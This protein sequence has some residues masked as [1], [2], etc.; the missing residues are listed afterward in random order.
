MRSFI[1]CGAY[2]EICVSALLS[3]SSSAMI[4]KSR[5]D[6]I[7]SIAIIELMN[8]YN[9]STKIIKSMIMIIKKKTTTLWFSYCQ[10][11]GELIY[12]YIILDIGYAITFLSCFATAPAEEHYKALKDIA[13][14]LASPHHQLGHYLLAPRVSLPHVLL[15]QPDI[16]PSLP[17]FPKIDLHQLVGYLDVAHATDLKT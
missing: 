1:A 2:H 12:A 15:P 7:K 3:L 11:L 16:D 9:Q 13:K 8:F 10:V 5:K 6:I 17:L 14:Y 4:V